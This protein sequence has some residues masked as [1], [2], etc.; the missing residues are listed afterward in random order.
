M[1]MKLIKTCD[2]CPEQYDVINPDTD[3]M[4][5][6]IR[7]RWGRFRVTCPD[8]GGEEVICEQISD[9]PIGIFP[10]EHR[11]QYLARALNAISKWH[12]TGRKVND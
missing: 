12:E 11:D 3:V 8:F 9:D 7:L 2:A 4:L 6:Y 10:D 1:P 5:G